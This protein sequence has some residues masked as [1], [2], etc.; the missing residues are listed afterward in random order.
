M[1]WWSSAG[2]AGEVFFAR[3]LFDQLV[4]PAHFFLESCHRYGGRS[5]HLSASP[6]WFVAQNIGTCVLSLFRPCFAAQHASYRG[7][8]Y[9]E[10]DG[11]FGDLPLLRGVLPADFPAQ[12]LVEA[13]VGKGI[14]PRLVVESGLSHLAT[15]ARRF[16]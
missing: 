10:P 8:W 5:F 2:F 6:I 9:A 1:R 13:A 4:G 12:L 7:G 14:G 15:L 16:G 11:E 3:V